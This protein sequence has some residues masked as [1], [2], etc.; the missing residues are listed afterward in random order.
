M[1]VLQR[2]NFSQLNHKKRASGKNR[3]RSI[4]RS[5]EWTED[6]KWQLREAFEKEQ[7]LVIS[8]IFR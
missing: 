8:F 7:K 5:K 1:K 6:V 2:L 4:Q 3:S